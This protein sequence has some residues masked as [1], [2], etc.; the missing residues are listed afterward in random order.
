MVADGWRLVILFLRCYYFSSFGHSSSSLCW[1]K[2]LNTFP[3]DKKSGRGICVRFFFCGRRKRV[4]HTIWHS[5]RTGSR[6]ARQVHRKVPSTPNRGRTLQKPPF[7][8]KS[9]PSNHLK[10]TEYN[11]V[12]SFWD[13]HPF[14]DSTRAR[15]SSQQL[16]WHRW[17]AVPTILQ[18][19]VYG[20]VRRGAN[21]SDASN[22]DV[23]Q[24]RNFLFCSNAKCPSVKRRT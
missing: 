16:Q 9:S 14:R 7:P 10:I 8:K 5:I 11:S 12:V 13:D 3:C 4:R 23:V 1:A 6:S 21:N 24:Q 20:G 15:T 22:P 17:S 18:N 19:S 2:W